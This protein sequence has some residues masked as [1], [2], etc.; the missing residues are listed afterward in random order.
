[1]AFSEQA[2][3][4]GWNLQITLTTGAGSISLALLDDYNL[5]ETPTKK[6]VNV[7]ASVE[8]EEMFTKKKLKLSLKGMR[9]L[10]N[11]YS[12]LP[13]ERQRITGI[14]FTYVD[15]DGTPI[16]GDDLPN[17]LATKYTN[18]AVTSKKA[19]GGV[20]EQKWDLEIENGQVNAVA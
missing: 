15:E 12:D 7:C 2:R 20:D 19:S 5:D 14:E 18:I 10:S 17:D 11:C 9:G 8:E 16:E 13:A 6:G 1:M 3:L 4:M